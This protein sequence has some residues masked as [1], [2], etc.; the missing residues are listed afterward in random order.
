MPKEQSFPYE[1]YKPI[2]RLGFGSA[3][4]VYK[5]HDTMLNRVVA[6][7]TLN[8]VSGSQII[9]FQREARA[10]STLQHEAIVRVLDFGVTATGSPFLVMEFVEGET[11]ASRLADSGC[12]PIGTALK[13]ITKVGE[14]LSHA[15]EKGIFHR[16]IKPSN[17]VISEDGDMSSVKIVDFGIAQME[18]QPGDP[19]NAQGRTIV[20]TPFYMS[21]D[22]IRGESYDAAS[23][24]YSLSCTLFETLTGH[25][26]FGG[27][28]PLELLSQHASIPP[29][30]LGELGQSGALSPELEAVVRKGLAKSKDK[31]F[32]SMPELIAA[33]NAVS[34]SNADAAIAT[35]SDTAS[36]KELRNVNRRYAI[37]FIGGLLAVVAVVPLLAINV[38]TQT[39]TVQKPRKNLIQP[40][41]VGSLNMFA[42]DISNE[43]ISF[44]GT[45]CR[46]NGID[47]DI[48]TEQFRRA[49]R[50]HTVKRLTI[51]GVHPTPEDAVLIKSLNIERL[52]L[53]E[54]QCSDEVMKILSELDL[55]RLIIKYTLM[56]DGA[57]RY[58]GKI[59]TL[60]SLDLTKTNI[61]DKGLSHL[62]NAKRLNDLKLASSEL[63]TGEGLA[64]LQQLV[65]LD[66]GNTP[67]TRAGL[68][69][70]CS[71]PELRTLKIAPT[72]L[73]DEDLSLLIGTKLSGLRVGGERITG[74]GI[75]ELS[76]I[77]HLS[78]IELNEMPHVTES[79]IA[80]F[81]KAR[82]D[83]K[84]MIRNRVRY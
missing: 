56:S 67:I 14:G 41:D 45:S 18:N 63:V 20:G 35:V 4:S 40:A 55:S 58:I 66:L 38:L 39:E 11:L 34:A 71:L 57:L 74:A 64:G 59:E 9:D 37:A 1:R 54:S 42:D 2:L 76:K 24:V 61:T 68:I 13:L 48:D 80:N 72:N 27:E 8:C 28:S 10:L 6:V 17:I 29:P 65:C 46:I 32:R 82:P 25:A 69:T 83:V 23:E 70:I 47:G 22:Q 12:L 36:A 73:S 75:K 62:A 30:T 33:L 21:P 26:P 5:C 3:A 60:N 19:S 15:H 53:L 50:G 78:Q 81:R 31:R 52:D 79:D 44:S 7:K 77:P 49:V 43:T 84:V 51:L 16:D